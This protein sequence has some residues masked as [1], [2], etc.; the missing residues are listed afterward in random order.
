MGRAVAALDDMGFRT[1]LPDAYTMREGDRALPVPPEPITMLHLAVAADRMAV[2]GAWERANSSGIGA[3]LVRA[4][5][6]PDTH[7]AIAAQS[8]HLLAQHARDVGNRGRPL[9]SSVNE[10]GGETLFAGD[11]ADMGDD[12]NLV[13]LLRAVVNMLNLGSMDAA[14][15]QPGASVSATVMGSRL[16]LGWSNRGAVVRRPR[17]SAE[18]APPIAGLTSGGAETRVCV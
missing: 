3:A 9:L 8:Q 11:V 7:L 18:C 13:G 2:A 5:S 17:V 10:T 4:R 6:D 12:V 15:G 16:G 14:A 1:A